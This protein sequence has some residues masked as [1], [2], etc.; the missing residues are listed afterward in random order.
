[1]YKSILLAWCFLQ[2]TYAF[3]VSLLIMAARITESKFPV[4]KEISNKTEPKP[5]TV[6]L[7]LLFFAGPTIVT[8][9]PNAESF[10]PEA[11]WGKLLELSDVLSELSAI[12]ELLDLILKTLL[13]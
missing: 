11:L 13:T 2:P 12:S 7:A 1:M 4:E 6:M 8:N 10:I 3:C 9:I 5:S